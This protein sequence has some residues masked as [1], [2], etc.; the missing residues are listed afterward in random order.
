MPSRKKV[1][2]VRATSGRHR[3][4]V[5]AGNRVLHLSKHEFPTVGDAK[6]AGKAKAKDIEVFPFCGPGEWPQLDAVILQGLCRP[7]LL[8]GREITGVALGKSGTPSEFCRE[9]WEERH[10]GQLER[11]GV[12]Q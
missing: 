11:W 12:A 4:V 6:S 8:K 9:C 3:F 10:P 7:C 5:V 1:K 2:T